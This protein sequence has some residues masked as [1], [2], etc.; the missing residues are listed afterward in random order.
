MKVYV[1]SSWRNQIQPALVTK[2]RA[3]GFEVYDFK[4]ALGFRW[5]DLD[6]NWRSWTTAEFK[7][8]L[9]QPAAVKGYDADMNALLACDACVL[10]RPCGESANFELGLACGLS[11]TTAVLMPDGCEPELMHKRADFI[12]SDLDQI[13]SFLQTR[14]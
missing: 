14:R 4:D 5:K 3:A 12:T 9:N 10:V 11:K 7:E 6:P 8:A 2:L 13:V 1:A